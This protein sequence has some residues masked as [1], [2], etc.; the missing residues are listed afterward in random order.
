[1]LFL[2]DPHQSN[3][4]GIISLR[5]SPRGA[6]PFPHP[7]SAASSTAHNLP[8][9]LPSSV[10][11]KPFVCH[12][13]ENCW[14]GVVFFPVWNLTLATVLSMLNAECHLTASA[15]ITMPSTRPS[16]KSSTRCYPIFPSLLVMPLP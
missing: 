7:E 14:V 4:Q 15:S 13:Y 6:P 2:A 16:R 12:A 8:Y 10:W 1:M 9:L 3:L 5:K 11:H